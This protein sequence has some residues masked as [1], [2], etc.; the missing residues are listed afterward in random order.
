MFLDKM[1]EN[2]PQ[3]VPHPFYLSLFSSPRRKELNTSCQVIARSAA[4]SAGAM[5]VSA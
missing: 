1:K 5:T 3:T 2:G 4:F